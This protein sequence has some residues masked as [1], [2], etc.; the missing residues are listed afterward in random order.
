VIWATDLQEHATREGGRAPH[1]DPLQ[2]YRIVRGGAGQPPDHRDRP[3]WADGNLL[4]GAAGD[5]KVGGTMRVHTGY[6]DQP[7]DPLIAQAEG[8]DRCPA[9]RNTAYVVFEDLELADFGNRIPSSRSRSSPT[10]MAAL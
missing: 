5:L 2:L 9:F 7:V 4:R 10:A 1:G 6:G 3:I 8:I